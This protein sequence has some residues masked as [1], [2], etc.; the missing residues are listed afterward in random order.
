MFERWFQRH[1][2]RE[3]RIESL[4]L[5]ATSVALGLHKCGWEAIRENLTRDHRSYA[6]SDGGQYSAKGRDDPG[7]Q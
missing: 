4:K 3:Y 5:L 1:S 6:S 7:S 2:S